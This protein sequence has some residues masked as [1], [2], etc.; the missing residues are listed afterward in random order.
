[1]TAYDRSGPSTIGRKCRIWGNRVVEERA[2]PSEQG[3]AWG[4]CGGQGAVLVGAG[5][6]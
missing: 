1:M 2:T 4:P 6:P 5:K 3:P